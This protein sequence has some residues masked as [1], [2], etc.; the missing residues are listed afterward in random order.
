MFPLCLLLLPR[1]AS[2]VTLAVRANARDVI[3]IYLSIYL[4]LS[5][6]RPQPSPPPLSASPPFP[7]P[8]RARPS[9][10]MLQ[11]GNKAPTGVAAAAGRAWGPVYA[12]KIGEGHQTGL[13]RG[14]WGAAI[15]A[16]AEGAG[17]LS[18]RC[19]ERGVSGRLGA[20]EGLPLKGKLANPVSSTSCRSRYRL[21]QDYRAPRAWVP[22]RDMC[23]ARA[24]DPVQVGTGLW[25]SSPLPPTFFSLSLPLSISLCIFSL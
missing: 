9:H 16:A 10:W 24:V 19:V 2:S 18:G 3:S 8:G 12:T 6:L 22:V 21:A 5:L 13:G 23:P 17:Q 1:L 7:G 15:G 25:V 4:S 11:F 20:G 14:G